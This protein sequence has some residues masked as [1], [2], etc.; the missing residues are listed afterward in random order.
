MHF[1]SY[2]SVAFHPLEHDMQ[3][4]RQ[5]CLRSALVYDVLAR[6]MDMKTR[7]ERLQQ[8]LIVNF[9]VKTGHNRQ[10]GFDNL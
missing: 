5:G 9:S 4:L 3:H 2:A 1:F 8:R 6:N 10:D 7:P